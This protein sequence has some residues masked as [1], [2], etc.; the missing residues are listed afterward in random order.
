[1]VAGGAGAEWVRAAGGERAGDTVGR[2]GDGCFPWRCWGM[3]AA[4]KGTVVAGQLL[5]IHAYIHIES[6]V[7]GTLTGTV[8]GRRLLPGGCHRAVS[9]SALPRAPHRRQPSVREGGS[10]GPRTSSP[11]TPP[12][13]PPPSPPLVTCK[14]EESARKQAPSAAGRRGV[15]RSGTPCPQGAPCHHDGMWKSPATH[16]TLN[17][18]RELGGPSG[19]R[20]E[21]RAP[22]RPSHR[23]GGPQPL[24]IRSHDDSCCS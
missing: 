24:I 6:G 18:S 23:K 2:T 14:R 5:Y 13:P 12:S 16:A 17:P 20:T 9:L 3:T 22:R 15:K 7:E 8:K 21:K 4:V 1:M 11:P 10:V 19:G